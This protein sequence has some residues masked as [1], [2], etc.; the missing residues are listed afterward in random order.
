MLHQASAVNTGFIM[1]QGRYFK[2]LSINEIKFILA[3]LWY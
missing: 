1:I 3:V 2:M